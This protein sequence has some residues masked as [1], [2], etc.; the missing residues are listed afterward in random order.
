[1]SAPLVDRS[2]VSRVEH[3]TVSWEGMLW[4]LGRIDGWH[5]SRFARA[6]AHELLLLSC[7]SS[8]C[9]RILTKSHCAPSRSENAL[10]PDGSTALAAHLG[11][12]TGLQTLYLWCQALRGQGWRV[13]GVVEGEQSLV[14]GYI[15][16]SGRKGP[17]KRVESDRCLRCR[18]PFARCAALPP[19]TFL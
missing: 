12:L 4:Q 10:G 7:F 14:G 1:M 5:P 19:A 3:I 9:E 8:L 11:R 13:Q 2:A 6:C 15:A 17:F 18:A 16:V